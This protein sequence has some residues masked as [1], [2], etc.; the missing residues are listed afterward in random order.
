MCHREGNLCHGTV[1]QI[2]HKYYSPAACPLLP[3]HT[4]EMYGCLGQLYRIKKLKI[5]CGRKA[6][7]EMLFAATAISPSC[8]LAPNLHLPFLFLSCEPISAYHYCSPPVLPTF[9]GTPSP[10]QATAPSSRDCLPPMGRSSMPLFAPSPPPASM[11][12]GWRL[13]LTSGSRFFVT[14]RVSRTHCLPLGTV[15]W[16]GGSGPRV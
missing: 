15:R 16:G 4:Q 6:V 7:I 3:V 10:R 9:S 11:T 1:R 13:P 8:S 2:H 14:R 5:N 12:V